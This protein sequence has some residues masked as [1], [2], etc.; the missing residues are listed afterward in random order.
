VSLSF[1]SPFILGL[2]G[3]EAFLDPKEV[4]LFL[5]FLIGFRLAL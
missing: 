3:L 1:D 4:N 2:K 5:E